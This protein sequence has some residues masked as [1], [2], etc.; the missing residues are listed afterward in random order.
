MDSLLNNRSGTTMRLFVGLQVPQNEGVEA[1]AADLAGLGL[2]PTRDRH[3][4][5]KF[6]GEVEETKMEEIRKALDTAAGFGP[7]PV[8]LE[9]VGAFPDTTYIRVVWIGCRSEKLAA[10]QKI[11]DSSLSA[12]GFP[13]ESREWIPHLTLARVPRRMPGLPEYVEKNAG[14]KFGTFNAANIA[15]VLSVLKPEGPEYTELHRVML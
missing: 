10:L 4:T 15:L 14:R 8:V 11:V 1:V 2:R 7:F 9:G 12:L 13:P 5:L 3:I 6:L